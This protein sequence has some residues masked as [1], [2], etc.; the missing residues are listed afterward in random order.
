MS[1]A[2]PLAGGPRAPAGRGPLAA[3]ALV[4]ALALLLASFPARNLDVWGHLAGGRALLAGDLAD[5]SRT[6][7]YDVLAYRLYQLG[8]GALLAAAKALAVAATGLLVFAACRVRAGTA[9]AAACAALAVLAAGVRVPLQPVTVSYLFFALALRLALRPA[10]RPGPLFATFALW[11]NCDR[12]AVVGLGTVALVWLGRALDSAD[13]RAELR[14]RGR[15]LLLL[16]WACALSPAHARGL[17]PPAEALAAFGGAEPTAAFGRA[18]LLAIG[19]SPAGRAY[20]V[21]LGLGA[22]AVLAARGGR[23]WE[24]LLPGLVL[25]ALSAGQARAVPFFALVGGPALAWH[26]AAVVERLNPNAAVA[27]AG[28]GA[29]VLAVLVLLACAWPGWL[30]GPPY[31]TR[32][33]ALDVPAGRGRAAAVLDE[34]RAAGALA[35]GTRTLHGS[36][37]AARSFAWFA[38]ADEGVAD[39]ALV[40]ALTDPKPEGDPRAKLRAAGVTRAVVAVGDPGRAPDLLE[41]LLTAPDEWPLLSAAG[42][43]A[44]FG[45]RDPAGPPGAFAAHELDLA[46]LAFRPTEDE[47]LPPVP[48]PP[49]RRPWEALWKRLP[50]RPPE[51]DEATLLL[52]KAEADR[53]TSPDRH[54]RA[55]TGWQTAGIIGAGATGPGAHP[56]ALGLR[57]TL[58]VPPQ[59]KG[60]DL[61]PVTR[62]AF[63]LQGAFV[64][65]RGDAPPAALFAAVRAARRAAAADPTDPAPHLTLGR[66]YLRLADATAEPLW[67]ARLPVLGQLR[68][69]Q[70]AGAFARAVALNPNLPAA[71]LELG[72]LYRRMNCGDLA[73]THLRAYRALVARG[74]GKPDPRASDEVMARLAD[75]LEKHTRDLAAEGARVPVGDRAFL[76]AQRGLAGEALKLLLGSD[77]SAFGT[78]GMRLE[79]DLLLKTGRGR[80]LLVWAT[81]ELRAALTPPT[82]HWLR[83]QALLAA[84]D[85][86]AADLEMAAATE[87]PATRAAAGARAARLT[88]KAVLDARPGSPVLADLPWRVLV[89]SDYRAELGAAE[90]EL[91]NQ[92][93]ILAVRGL[94]ALEAGDTDR[95]LESFRAALAFEAGAAL[96][97]RV[98]FPARPIAAAGLSWL[99]AAPR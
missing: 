3:G 51:R 57:L 6:W 45:W 19:D 93:D 89:E 54:A 63:G 98:E 11:A 38:P 95:A 8:G 1:S 34:L 62:T 25:A 77:V 44:V 52:L 74:G 2:P 99:G 50:P 67:A 4:A 73:V 14:A 65:A 61:P 43:V 35:P 97:A 20:F 58:A 7:L 66:C 70:A 92:C 55:W 32:A 80:E 56:L 53:I 40:A 83:A 41:R 12:W 10:G 91:A 84:G 47:K 42:G 48:P 72:A 30:Q 85:Y 78:S 75:L 46:R 69:A 96:G 81:P 79:L 18:Y 29:G 13:G 60:T 64:A 39:E 71:H 17:V 76:A 23:V 36:A 15:A 21:L 88:G 26:A 16:A 24:L 22:G 31:G 37:E 49:D 86:A 59:G 28:R 87:A 82:Y 27:R 9:L 94:V 68:L 33:W 5:V 90:R